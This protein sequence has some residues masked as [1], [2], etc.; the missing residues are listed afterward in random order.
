MN[1][2][3]PATRSVGAKMNGVTSWQGRFIGFISFHLLRG[4][5]R[6]DL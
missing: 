3:I 6:A 5:L 4:I 1:V 2:F